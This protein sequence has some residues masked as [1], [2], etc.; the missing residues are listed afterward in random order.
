MVALWN[1]TY[2]LASDPQEKNTQTSQMHLVAG[3]MG[4]RS[5]SLDITP[6]KSQAAGT[7][8]KG[9]EYSVSLWKVPLLRYSAFIGKYWHKKV[10]KADVCPS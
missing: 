3:G 7:L 8:T 2:M 1:D 9:I 5:P 6:S 4:P 10:T